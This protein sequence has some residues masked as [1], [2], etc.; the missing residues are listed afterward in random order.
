MTCLWCPSV[1]TTT[2]APQ[3]LHS[4]HRGRINDFTGQ[5]HRVRANFADIF[6]TLSHCWLVAARPRG[7]VS[8]NLLAAASLPKNDGDLRVCMKPREMVYCYGTDSIKRLRTACA[9]YAVPS[10]VNVGSEQWLETLIR[11]LGFGNA[12]T[13]ERW[14]AGT[15][16]LP[17]CCCSIGLWSMGLCCGQLLSYGNGQ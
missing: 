5:S 12:G 9:V 8:H 3:C 1:L 17:D 7:I 13:L 14:N 16:V 11:L 10:F 4:E 6:Q 15:P 2:P